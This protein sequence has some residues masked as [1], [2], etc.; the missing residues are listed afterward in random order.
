V[1]PGTVVNR[2]CPAVARVLELAIMCLMRL[3]A[4]SPN[5]SPL[6]DDLQTF[7]CQ[8]GT[9]ESDPRRTSRHPALSAPRTHPKRPPRDIFIPGLH[10]DT[11]K[12]RRTSIAERCGHS[13]F[14][15]RYI[16]R[17]KAASPRSRLPPSLGRRVVTPHCAFPTQS[18]YRCPCCERREGCANRL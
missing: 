1:I 13:T 3:C 4:G 17:K 18:P 7:V 6:C 16:F 8:R 10:I 15:S 5:A 9:T 14:V 12:L 11:L 2:P